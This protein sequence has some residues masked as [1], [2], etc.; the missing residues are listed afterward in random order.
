MR[1]AARLRGGL[2]EED[3]VGWADGAPNMRQFVFS[4]SSVVGDPSTPIAA[5][6]SSVITGVSSLRHG[7]PHC[8][9]G[10]RR[11]GLYVHVRLTAPR[12]YN[13]QLLSVNGAIVPVGRCLS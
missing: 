5:R 8:A 11:G 3:R 9:G 12:E 2:V 13:R 7:A 6:I 1:V 4:T 10:G